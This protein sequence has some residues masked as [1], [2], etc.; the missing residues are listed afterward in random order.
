MGHTEIGDDGVTTSRGVS[1]VVQFASYRLLK[2]GKDETSFD[3]F[4]GERWEVS[5]PFLPRARVVLRN[6]FVPAALL[7]SQSLLGLLA[8]QVDVD[9]C[10]C[11]VLVGNGSQHVFV[12]GQPLCELEASE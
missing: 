4:R 8:I 1:E 3:A 7:F 6:L 2:V 10:S 12:V 9:R 11:L 5:K